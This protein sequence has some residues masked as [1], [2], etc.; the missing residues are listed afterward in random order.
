VLVAQSFSTEEE[1][2]ARANSTQYGLN[3]TMFT[4]DIERAFRVADRLQ[5]GEVDVNV[6]FT[7]LIPAGRG[8]PRKSSGLSKRGLEG[9]QVQKALNIQIRS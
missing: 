8:E 6:H 5:C 2:I 7:P 4:R 3:A 9:Y 1:A